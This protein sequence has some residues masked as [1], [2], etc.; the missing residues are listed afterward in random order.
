MHILTQNHSMDV[1][2]HLT[3]VNG[4]S[5]YAMYSNFTIGPESDNYRLH[6]QAG[7]YSGNAGRSIV[8]RQ[9]ADTVYQF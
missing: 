9:K 4:T 3:A 7:S 8:S 2:F 1:Y 6:F 5:Y